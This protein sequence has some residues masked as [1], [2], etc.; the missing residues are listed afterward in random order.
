MSK[1]LLGVA[2]ADPKLYTLLQ[3]AFDATGELE[4]L[5]VSIIHIADPQDDEVFGGD[6]EGLAD[7][8]LEELARSYVQLDALYREC[9]GKRLEGHRM[10]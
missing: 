9:T 7:Y 10:R 6:F 8:G 2:I 1:Q 4:H 5:R 3:S